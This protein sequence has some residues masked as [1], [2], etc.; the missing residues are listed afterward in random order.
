MRLVTL[1]SLATRRLRS[2]LTLFG[3]ILGVAAMFSI[4]YV[5]QNAYD[6][7]AQ[8]FE[9]TSGKVSLEVRN[10]ANIGGFPQD[11]LEDVQNTEGVAGAFPVLQVLAA[12]PGETPEEVTL[13]FSGMGSGGLTLYGIDPVKDPDVRDYQITQGSFLET[14]SPTIP[15][16]VL[17]EDY[18]LEQEIE[19]G[20]TISILTAF[21]LTDVEVV[22]LMA[23]EGAGMTNMGKFGVLELGEAQKIAHRE[24]EIDRIDILSD[25]RESDPDFLDGLRNTLALEL[26]D[27]YAVVYPANQGR[28]MSQMLTGYQ[29]SLNFMAGIALFVG[30]FL[31]YNALSMTVAERSRELGMLRCV[32]MT[33]SQVSVQVIIEGFILGILGAVAGAGVG[34]FMSRGLTSLMA[35]I[36]GQPLESGSIPVDILATSMGIGLFVTLLSAFIPAYQAG[37]ISPMVALQSRSHKGSGRLFRYGWMAGLLLLVLSVVILVWN[38]F[39]Y[40]VQFRL[41]SMTVFS[42]F[43]GATLMIPVTLRGWQY[44][45]RLPLRL[46]FGNLGEIGSRNLERAPKRTMLTCAALM[47]GVS[48]IVSTL[49]ITGSFTADLNEWMDAYM[50]G[51]IYVGAAVPLTREL[52]GNLESLP[53]VETASPVRTIEATWLREDVEEKISLMGVDPASYTAITRFVY[54]DK[55]TD[56]DKALAELSKGE[57]I[58]ISEVIAEK[59][60]VK[61]GDQLTLKTRESDR[62]FT[63]SAVVLDFSNQGLVVT[64]NLSDLEEYFEVE[65]VNTF[66]V[67]AKEGVEISETI[68]QIKDGY[69]E[70]YQLII[71]S[72]SAIKERADALM[73]QAFSMFDVLGILAVMVAALGVLNTLSMSVVERT[74]EIGMLRS[75]GMTRF[76]VVRMIL[77]EAGLMG[78]IGGL[79]GLGL[80]LLLTKI[81]LAAMGAMSGYNLEFIVPTKAL[82]M[83]IVVALVTS[84]LAALLPAIR[85]AKT[86]MLSAIHYE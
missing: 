47:V 7:I 16:I 8:L 19:V 76:Q 48:M 45:S 44:L 66:Y 86:P 24:G 77:A 1:R 25:A 22:G 58:F 46:L 67:N 12:L 34:I 50:G 53:G 81:L 52:Q 70:D 3:I 55:E 79:L 49:G 37:R 74:R 18:A 43:L 56:Q 5:N 13:S 11:V 68:R 31:I 27:S 73:Q 23:K 29:L 82:W 14:S 62:A 42:L 83:S 41:G 39:P 51:D 28:Q 57:S 2:F 71:E 63:V 30:A 40:D 60:G 65:D 4:N 80:G 21:G 75:M 26:G 64:G 10:A 35:Q 20:Q 9:G 33:R 36:L 84:Q 15:Q 61:V 72:N 38:P 85:A 54:S 17:V 32:G 6:S 78:I 59:Y 69:Q